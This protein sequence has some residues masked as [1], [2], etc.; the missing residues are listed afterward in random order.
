MLKLMDSFTVVVFFEVDV[1]SSN[2]LIACKKIILYEG[3][4][5]R[6]LVNKVEGASNSNFN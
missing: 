1:Q 2:H 3:L 4:S 6:N 5:I